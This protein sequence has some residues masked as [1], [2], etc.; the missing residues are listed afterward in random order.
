[1]IS[2]DLYYIDKNSLYE[3]LIFVKKKHIHLWHLQCHNDMYFF[4]IPLSQRSRIRQFNVGYIKTIGFFSYLLLF[5]KP[6]NMI[7]FLSFMVTIIICSHLIFD[8]QII[9]SVPNI[10]EHI[11]Q[12]LNNEN[13]TYFSLLK[14]YEDLNDLLSLLKQEYVNDVEYMNVYQSG[15][16]VYL[17]YTKRQQESVVENDYRNIYASKDGLIAYFDVDSGYIV[18]ET[19]DYVLQGDLLVSNEII[20]TSNDMKIIPVKG[21]VY[22]YTF[23]DYEASIDNHNQDYGDAFYELLLK[24]RSQIPTNAIID[25]ENVL[26]MTKTSSTITLKMHYTLIEDIAVKGDNNEE[27]SETG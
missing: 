10:S 23:N 16:V 8:I 24:I 18:A 9:G 25:R 2:Y 5:F 26:Q 3:L 19:N 21:H 14:S 4:Y 20:S 13:V 11:Y 17:E 15:S 7:G 6:L 12:T 1:M 27:N 22:A